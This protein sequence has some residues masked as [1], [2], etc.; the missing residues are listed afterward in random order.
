[1]SH[2]SLSQNLMIERDTSLTNIFPYRYTICVKGYHGDIATQ[3]SSKFKVRPLANIHLDP[4]TDIVLHKTSDSSVK[5]QWFP[6]V[7]MARNSGPIRGYDVSSF[8]S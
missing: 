6:P 5:L 7:A 3:C 8:S 1:M 2:L 4:P